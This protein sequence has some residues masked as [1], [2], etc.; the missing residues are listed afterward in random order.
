MRDEH[1]LDAHIAQVRLLA[2]TRISLLDIALCIKRLVVGRSWMPWVDGH[3]LAGP[4]GHDLCLERMPL[5]LAGVQTPTW[6]L[7]ARTRQG[8]FEAVD[9]KKRLLI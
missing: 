7:Q 5:L 1:T 8:R 4:I 3:D 2:G 6:F 9:E